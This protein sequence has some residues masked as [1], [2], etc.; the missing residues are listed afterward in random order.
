M[1]CGLDLQPVARYLSLKGTFIDQLGSQPEKLVKD[2]HIKHRLE[3]DGRNN[4]HHITVVN[5]LEIA[6]LVELDMANATHSDDQQAKLLKK[7]RR[8]KLFEIREDAIGL[9][10]PVARW[11]KPVDLGLGQ[12]RDGDAITYFR[13]VHWPFGQELRRQL[14]LNFTNFHITVGF[15]PNDVHLYKGPASLVCLQP[16]QHLPRKQAK[17]LISVASFYYHDQTFMKLLA[18]SCWRHGYYKETAKLAKVYLASKEV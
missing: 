18:S 4:G 7:L 11:E 6:S 5:H 12:C 16:D 13:V 2:V 14:G 8:E 1:S 3:R 15:A 9:L 17:L 10:G